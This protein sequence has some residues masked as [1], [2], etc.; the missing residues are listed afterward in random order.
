ML[1]HV[2]DHTS[3]FWNTPF[4]FKVNLCSKAVDAALDTGASLSAVCTNMISDV[5]ER[6]Q[7][8]QPWTLPPIQLANSAS[9]SPTGIVWLNIDLQGK[10]FYHQF[11][12]IPDLSSPLI[13]EMDFM[14]RA[15]VSIHVPSRTV[16]L[17]DHVTFRT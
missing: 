12:I 10:I 7:K 1:G 13:L 8:V 14:L 17:I 4:F 11:V 5:L 2:E 6:S 15:S 16:T 3:S 9:C